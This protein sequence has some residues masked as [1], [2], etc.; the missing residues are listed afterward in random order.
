MTTLVEIV[1]GLVAAVFASYL[2]RRPFH[3][4]AT[5][6]AEATA[7][8]FGQTLFDALLRRTRRPLTGL[9]PAGQRAVRYT[10]AFGLLCVMAGGV[11]FLVWRQGQLGATQDL[12]KI[13]SSDNPNLSSLKHASP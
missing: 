5:A 1:V 2:L 6:V 13:A 12:A 10:A 4:I 8:V 3:A 9:T 7:A 11:L